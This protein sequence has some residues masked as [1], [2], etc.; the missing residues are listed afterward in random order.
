MLMKQRLRSL[1]EDLAEAQ[2]ALAV[3]VEQGKRLAAA[4]AT[5]AQQLEEERRTAGERVLRVREQSGKE[6]EQQAALLKLCE[7]QVREAGGGRERLDGQRH[8]GDE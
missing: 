1:E 7:E 6:F 2:A 3:A 5:L 4:E 8:E